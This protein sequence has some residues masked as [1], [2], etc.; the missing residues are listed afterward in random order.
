MDRRAVGHVSRH[1]DDHLTTSADIE[2][3]TSV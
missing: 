3:M 2:R 1:L